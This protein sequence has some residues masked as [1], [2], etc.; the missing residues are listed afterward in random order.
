MFRNL[1]VTMR[2]DYQGILGKMQRNVS[3]E[4]AANTVKAARQP[5]GAR[6][7]NS[8]TKYMGK[9]RVTEGMDR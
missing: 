2:I 5:G 4:L 9:G 1:S 3:L 6:L 8:A 7:V